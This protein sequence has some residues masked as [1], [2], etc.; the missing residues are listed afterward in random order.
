[1]KFIYDI[2]KYNIVQINLKPV[3]LQSRIIRV[4]F[5]PA[6]QTIKY[7]SFKE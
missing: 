7:C 5:I 2:D 6:D 1:M 3:L 4:F